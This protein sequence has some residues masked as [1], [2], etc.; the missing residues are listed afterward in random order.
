MVLHSDVAHYLASALPAA[1][2]FHG[3]VADYGK[4]SSQGH[5]LPGLQTFC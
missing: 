4:T 5:L 2:V 1:W 3:R